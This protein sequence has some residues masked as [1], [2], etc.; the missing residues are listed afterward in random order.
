MKMA[1]PTDSAASEASPWRPATMVSV[2]PKAITASWPASTVRVARNA[3]QIGRLV[4]EVR[5]GC[6]HAL[7]QW[8]R[9]QPTGQRKG[10]RWVF[11]LVVFSMANGSG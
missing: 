4:G 8:L 5:M 3:G 7:V 1:E 11:A 10:A 6:G 2:T 9:W